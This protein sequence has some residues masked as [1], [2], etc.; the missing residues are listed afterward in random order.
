MKFSKDGYKRNSKDRNNPYNIIPSGNITMKDVDFP[1]FGIDNL[2]NIEI[3][4][5]GGEYKFPGDSVFEIPLA[6]MGTEFAKLEKMISD[7]LNNPGDKATDFSF[8]DEVVGLDEEGKPMLANIDNLR[9][10]SAGRYTAEEL[11]NKVRGIPYVGGILDATGVDKLVGF[12]GSNALGLGHEVA[13]LIEDDRSF[14]DALSE[15]GEDV[16]NN[17]VGSI[18]GSTDISSERKDNMLKFLS[19][20]NLLPDGYVATDKNFS[21]NVYFKD[22]MVM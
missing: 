4:M 10:A 8:S 1:V 21:D 9:H 3:M 11:Q 15:S 18:V 16:F 19:Y 22:Q 6:Q 20:N 14:F 7:Y 13:T 17:F 5:P 2:G 12:L